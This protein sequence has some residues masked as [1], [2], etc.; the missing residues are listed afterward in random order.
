MRF[1]V[2]SALIS[3]ALRLLASVEKKEY[4]VSVSA[5]KDTGSPGSVTITTLEAGIK[6]VS[7]GMSADVAEEGDVLFSSKYLRWLESDQAS[8]MVITKKDCIE[9]RAAY[10]YR[11]PFSTE[12]VPSIPDHAETGSATFR[13]ADC[14]ELF[15]RVLFAIGD[16]KDPRHN[17]R[18]VQLECTGEFLRAVGG[19]RRII[20]VSQIAQAS[21]Y[22]GR[23]VLSKGGIYTIQK[24]EGDMVTLAFCDKGIK[25]S[26]CGEIMCD[27][28]LPELGITFPSY[29]DVIDVKGNT[30]ITADRETLLS[31]LTAMRKVSDRLQLSMKHVGYQKEKPRG[32]AREIEGPAQFEG[33][34]PA[35][36]EGDDLK[37]IVNAATLYEAVENAGSKVKIRFTNNGGPFSVSGHGDDYVAVMMP[38]SPVETR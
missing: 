14:K 1:T 12:T 10:N 13:L 5:R 28:Y 31:F 3:K 36:W 19:D 4:P 8:V 9:I 35:D 7:L 17:F 11:V 2:Q 33:Y 37:I 25:L 23:F 18:C 22:T 20:A 27:M 34:I 16:D 38:Y 21:A 6:F 32:Y 24:L 26:S 29:D 15:R 30:V